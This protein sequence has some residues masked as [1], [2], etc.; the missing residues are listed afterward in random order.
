VFHEGPGLIVTGAN[1]K[2][3]PELATFAETIAG[4]VYHLP[5]SSRLRMGEA[6]D[7][8]GL[9][10]N[11]FF[12]ELEVARPEA[13]R[14]EFHFQIV[15]RG[16]AEEAQLTL[17]LVLKPGEALE[18]GTARIVPGEER[19]DLGPE[20]LGGLI[21]HN[22]WT[23]RTDPTAR[24]IWPIHPF[25]PYANA[26]ETTLHYAV[27]ALSIP[28]NLQLR[29]EASTRFRTQIISFTLEVNPPAGDEA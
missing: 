15:E 12:A 22:G 28:L 7:R 24:L 8:L 19:I 10:Y 27:A 9:A 17:Q 25:S 5:L 23:L 6:R 11:T 2:R 21:R 3:Q 18:T 14:L 16:Q 20:A 1:S 29:P 13:D 4:Q 26:P